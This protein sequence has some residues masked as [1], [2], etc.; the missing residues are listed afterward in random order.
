LVAYVRQ[1]EREMDQVGVNENQPKVWLSRQWATR[2][3]FVEW[4]RRGLGYVY[5]RSKA[6]GGMPINFNIERFAQYLGDWVDE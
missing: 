6:E 5:E 3:T 1:I 2:E 4:C